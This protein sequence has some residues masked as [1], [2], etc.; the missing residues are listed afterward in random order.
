MKE[1]TLEWLLA[2]LSLREFAD[3]L[4]ERQPRVIAHGD[5]NYFRSLFSAADVDTVFEYNQPTPESFRVIMQG[6]GPPRNEYVQSDGRLD[7]DQLRKFYADGYTI[8]VNGLE[9]FWG[10]VAELVQSLQSRLSYRVQAN[11][12]LTPRGYQGL[13]PHY[14]SHSV[15]VT[16]LDGVK[17]WR[18]YEE[19]VRLPLDEM[20]LPSA[21]E[22]DSLPEPRVF[23]LAPGDVIY[24]PRGWVHEAETAKESSLHLTLG[25]HP[26]VWRDLMAKALEAL[27]LKN[28]NLRRS[29]PIG[30]LNDARAVPDF[31]RE[32][33]ELTDL[34]AHECS[35]AEAVGMLQ[36]DFLRLTRSPP[37]GKFVTSLDR[38]PSIDLQTRLVKRPRL[39]SRVVPVGDLVAIQFSRSLV[40]GPL[41]YREAM[42]F[43][44]ESRSPFPVSDVPGLTDEEK[45]SFGQRLV[46]DGLL[47]FAD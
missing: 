4:W 39:H 26:P 30:Y 45:V 9:R 46:R 44:V 11:L 31:R 6:D 28:E 23:D 34:M 1:R 8:V 42:V 12:Y 35:A 33:E 13:R 19:T 3:E 15:I 22:R 24:I 27:T 40:Q 18:L 7:L 21:F 29:L 10:P 16:Q 47:S 20:K 32:F 2:P 37:D 36:D 14:D 5:R 43:V 17:T 38:L 41:K 25:I